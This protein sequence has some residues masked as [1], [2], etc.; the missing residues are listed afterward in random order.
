MFSIQRLC[1]Y[2]VGIYQIIHVK[3]DSCLVYVATPTK[4]VLVWKRQFNVFE[5]VFDKYLILTILC[6]LTC[7]SITN[8]VFLDL[9]E[10][11]LVQYDVKIEDNPIVLDRP[12]EDSDSSGS[13][14]VW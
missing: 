6:R 10:I 4:F 5:M 8:S 9:N 7:G 11:N 13:P 2:E 3:T 1:D 14:Q 12:D